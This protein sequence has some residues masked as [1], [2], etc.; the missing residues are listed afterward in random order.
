MCTAMSNDLDMS[1][2]DKAHEKLPVSTD[3]STV[4]LKT[5]VEQETEPGQTEK[6]AHPCIFNSIDYEK[7]RQE[8][9][10]GVARIPHD[11]L[12]F[13]LAEL[14]QP[15][16][17]IL[18]ANDDWTLEPVADGVKWDVDHV[19][20]EIESSING[21]LAEKDIK[22]NR[23]AFVRERMLSGHGDLAD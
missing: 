18:H 15:M 5:V 17:R 23:A 21:F 12:R 14:E 19:P 3:T 13:D 4:M 10:P 20:G 1:P 11:F 2:T 6:V 22:G 8:Y 7:L 16:R 9:N